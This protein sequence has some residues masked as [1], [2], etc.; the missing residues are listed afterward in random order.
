MADEINP[1]EEIQGLVKDFLDDGK[2]RL[3]ILNEGE[4]NLPSSTSSS[5]ATSAARSTRW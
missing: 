2:S 3:R 4:M 1:A 5:R